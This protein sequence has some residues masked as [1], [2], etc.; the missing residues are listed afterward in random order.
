MG[1]LTSPDLQGTQLLHK[2]D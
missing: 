2:S 1:N